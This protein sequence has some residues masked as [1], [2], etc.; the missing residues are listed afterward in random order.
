[1]TPQEII[2]RIKTDIFNECINKVDPE[3]KLQEQFWNMSLD[4]KIKYFVNN[5]GL[6]EIFN[7]IERNM[8]SYSLDHKEIEDIDNLII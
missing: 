6:D 2:A 4:D 7:I 3:V 8:Y 1:M 5:I